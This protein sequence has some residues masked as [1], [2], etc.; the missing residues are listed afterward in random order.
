[1]L[2]LYKKI[3]IVFFIVFSTTFIFSQNSETFIVIIGGG[4]KYSDAMAAKKKYLKIVDKQIQILSK[5]EIIKSDTVQ[6]LN[7][8]YYIAVL[9]YSADEYRADW[10]CSIVNSNMTGVYKKKVFLKNINNTIRLK[11]ANV[12]FKT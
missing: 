11:I 9:G 3:F 1:M 5:V 4:T 7:P 12:P 2:L 10:I 8:G 6:G